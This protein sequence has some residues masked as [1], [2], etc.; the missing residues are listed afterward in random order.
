M[1]K[2]IQFLDSPSKRTV[3]VKTVLGHIHIYLHG[4]NTVVI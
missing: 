4:Y 1:F 2:E 3:L